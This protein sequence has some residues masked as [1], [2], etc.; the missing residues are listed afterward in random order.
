MT[1][2]DFWKIVKKK[3]RTF[4]LFLTF[5]FEVSEYKINEYSIETQTSKR[6]EQLNK[7]VI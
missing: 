2:R 7:T 5:K 1:C 4:Y 3:H 6:V